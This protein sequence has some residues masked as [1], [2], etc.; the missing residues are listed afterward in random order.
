MGPEKD[1][2]GVADSVDP[3][4]RILHGQLQVFR[5]Q[6]VDERERLVEI[7]HFDERAVRGKRTGHGLRTFERGEHRLDRGLH[8]IQELAIR[9]NQDRSGLFVV[10]RLRE[11]VHHHPVHRG[12]SIADDDYLRRAGQHVD[13]HDTEHVPLGRGH[14]LVP[15]S[16]DLVHRPNRSGAERKC[17]DGLRTSDRPHLVDPRQPGGS[18]HQRVQ[19]T[20]WGR[21]RHDDLRDTGHS[22]RNGVHQH[23]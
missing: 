9:R 20:G 5:R 16:D 8:P 4:L 14:V 15:G 7:A 17:R 19:L 3:V 1:G 22:R 21:H 6:A 12:T 13:P 2:P 18:E 10:F 23:R 11:Q